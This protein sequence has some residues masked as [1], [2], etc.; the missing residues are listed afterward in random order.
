MQN[1]IRHRYLAGIKFCGTAARLFLVSAILFLYGCGT[2]GM[3]YNNDIFA[4]KRKLQLK[5][6]QDALA[7][8]VHAA[9]VSPDSVAYAYAATAAFKLGDYQNAGQYLDQAQKLN[10]RSIAHLRIAG[11]RALILLKPE[12]TPDGLEALRNYI[13]VYERSEPLMSINQ[14]RSMWKSAQVDYPF[15]ERLMDE[16]ISIY[17][18]D[19]DDY[20]RGLPGWYQQKRYPFLLF[21][22]P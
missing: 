16:Q 13:D 3:M 1:N 22:L 19:V 18:D 6:Y 2:A 8:F 15:L 17:E 4:G 14:V 7:F 12:T 5:E 20:L 10:G 9:Q 21:Q 11:Y